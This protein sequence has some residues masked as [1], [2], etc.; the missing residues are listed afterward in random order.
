M[1]QCQEWSSWSSRLAEASEVLLVGGKILRTF[2][3]SGVFL[4]RIQRAPTSFAQVIL[5]RVAH[6]AT[7]GTVRPPSLPSNASATSS[8][9]RTVS[10]LLIFIFVTH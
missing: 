5:Q 10:V 4:E 2:G 3:D 7:L 9:R 6:D 1:A 8:S